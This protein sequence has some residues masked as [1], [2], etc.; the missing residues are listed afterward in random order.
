MYDL[1]AFAAHHPGG[2]QWLDLTK[3]TDI[4]EAFYVAHMAPE[5]IME[6]MMEKYKVGTC[7]DIPRR[8]LF[9]FER[10]GF[11]MTLKRK[12]AKVI[13]KVGTGPTWQMTLLQDGLLLAFHV[14]LVV[15]AMKASLML[16]IVAGLLLGMSSA[17]SH[18]FIHQKD[19]FRRC[20]IVV[21]G[22]RMR[23]RTKEEIG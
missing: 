11:Y 8:S 12:A 23:Q 22:T 14:V 15:A 6:G 7:A 18:N 2:R 19:N 5:T 1:S 4:T 20:F 21:V 3:G 13:G 9:T 10:D 16:T 17:S